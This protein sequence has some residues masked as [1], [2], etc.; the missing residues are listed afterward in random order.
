[1][2]FL[3]MHWSVYYGVERRTEAQPLKVHLAVLD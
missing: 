3:K 1:M 2:R